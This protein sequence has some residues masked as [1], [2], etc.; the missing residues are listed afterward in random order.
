MKIFNITP[1]VLLFCLSPLH[2][3]SKDDLDFLSSLSDYN[4]LRDILPA[5]LRQ[6]AGERLAE[7]ERQVARWTS[8]KDVTERQRTLRE[9]ITAQLGGFPERR[10]LLRN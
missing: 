9:R 3:Q 10:P 8:G 7:R 5:F 1:L 4:N 6:K 2:A